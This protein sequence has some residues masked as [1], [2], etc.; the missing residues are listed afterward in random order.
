MSRLSK[1]FGLS[2]VGLAKL[3]KR[4]NIPRPG[5]GYWRILETGPASAVRKRLRPLRKGENETI[6]IPIRAKHPFKQLKPSGKTST[7]QIQVAENGPFNHEFTRNLQSLSRQN[8]WIR[9][10]TVSDYLIPRCLRIYDALFVTLERMGYIIE[11]D[12]DRPLIKTSEHLVTFRISERLIGERHVPTEEELARQAKNEGPRPKYWEFSPSGRLRFYL[13][14]DHNGWKTVHRTWSDGKKQRVEKC[15]GHVIELIPK[16][17]EL[18]KQE[19][20]ERD[21]Q[22]AIWD[23]ERRNAEIERRKQEEYQRKATLAL[24][25]A[26]EWKDSGLLREFA[27]AL[28]TQCVK[29]MYQPTERQGIESFISWLRSH[30][31]AADPLRNVGRVLEEFNPKPNALDFDIWG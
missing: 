9:C 31:D 12:S 19:D 16:V 5:L 15:L 18:L 20:L 14:D 24:S 10:M 22:H 13:M 4:H 8:V 27:A 30:A 3:C 28:E 7:L 26:R 17:M 2:D 25:R 23:N 21:H 11:W 1:E 29:K 6:F